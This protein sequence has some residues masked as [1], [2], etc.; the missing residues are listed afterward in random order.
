MPNQGMDMEIF[1]PC[2]FVFASAAPSENEKREE[3]ITKNLFP[4]DNMYI[5]IVNFADPF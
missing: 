1:I 5:I 2:A 4:H 3:P